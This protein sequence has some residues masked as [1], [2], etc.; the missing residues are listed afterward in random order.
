MIPKYVP[1][2]ETRCGK[3]KHLKTAVSYKHHWISVDKPYICEAHGETL[4]TYVVNFFGDAC[5]EFEQK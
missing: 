4:P 3:C 2:A 1:I 5:E